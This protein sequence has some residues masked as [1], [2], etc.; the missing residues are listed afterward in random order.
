MPVANLKRVLWHLLGGTR[1]APLRIAILGI[2]RQR[3][4][5]TNQLAVEL[6]AD[7]KTIQHHLRVLRENRL[8]DTYAGG[9]EAS[10]YGQ[11]YFPTLELEASWPAY[12]ELVE[13]RNARSARAAARTPPGSAP[14]PATSPATSPPTSPPS[15]PPPT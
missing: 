12:D 15:R 11:T 3:P 7:Y 8:V 4:S 10:R 6:G 2:L 9:P 13:R 1:G 5:N 14:A